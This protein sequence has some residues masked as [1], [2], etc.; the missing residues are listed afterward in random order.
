MDIIKNNFNIIIL[1]IL[2]IILVL[3]LYRPDKILNEYFAETP[4]KKKRVAL[5][6]RGAVSKK[7]MTFEKMNELYE[8]NNEYVDYKACYNSIIKHIVEPNLNEYQFDIFCHGWNVDLEKNIVDMYSPV[9][10]LFEDNKKYNDY[11]KELCV[12]DRDFGG[13]SQALTMKKSIELKEQYEAEQNFKYDV[14][15][16][17]RYDI[18]L[19][20]DIILNNYTELK[21]DSIYVNRH[22]QISGDGTGDFH[23][24]MNSDV[25]GLFKNL[26]DSIQEGNKH[27]MH[28]WIKNYI[29]NYI[30]KPLLMDDIEP[31]KHQEV[32]RKIHEFSINIGHLTEEQLK[33]YS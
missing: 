30:K 32:I 19:W 27:V 33:S 16:L 9:K 28:H 1:L 29:I 12:S 17:Y 20:K 21:N 10:Y 7:D 23:F 26:I 22:T 4:I 6:M 3:L 5:C 31:G 18:F 14:V 24:V 11:I 15:I 8:N 2:L 25:S 13:I